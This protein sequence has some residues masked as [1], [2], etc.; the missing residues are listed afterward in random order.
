MNVL[1]VGVGPKRVGGMQKVSEIY[2]C[3]E[4]YQKAV[5][6]HYVYTTTNGS[7]L[8]RLICM[9]IGYLKIQYILRK[10]PIDIVH[11]HMA[12]KGS[13]FRKGVVAKWS[14]KRGKRTIIHLHAGPFMA[15]YDTLSP[16]L[17]K[18][19]VAIFEAADQVLVLGEYWKTELSSI[20][21]A[22]KIT[23]LYNGVSCPTKN[24]YVES[25]RNISYFGVMNKAKGIFD[26]IEAVQIID[27]QLPKD[28]KIYLCGNDL[29]G[30]VENVIRDKN[31]TDRFILT[32][33]VN[34]E[35][36]DEI[37]R[38]TMISILPSY[39]EGLSMTILE[40]MANG[41]PVITTNI[42]TMPEVLGVNTLGSYI[43]ELVNNPEER[44]NLSHYEFE[45][46]VS[47][48]SEKQFID[49]TLEIYR[50]LMN[51]DNQEE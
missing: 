19:V 48:F 44:R 9:I 23:V 12:E 16:K 45:R 34:G 39:F 4:V 20:I 10:K 18:K 31:L 30:N 35:I 37:Y 11:I 13:T 51:P 25:S 8:T 7:A 40:A 33:W 27:K 32:G 38:N 21:P 3:N 50:H 5:S 2:K 22:E 36:K 6:F 26:L 42:S 24:N 49:R 47:M 17:Q 28:I 29:D 41:I 15:W 43:L 14:K 1:M 46:V